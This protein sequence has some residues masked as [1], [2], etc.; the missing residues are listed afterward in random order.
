MVECKNNGR[1]CF[2]S[3]KKGNFRFI[4]VLFV[5]KVLD[6]IKPIDV[7]STLLKHFN[8]SKSFEFFKI[9][10]G[11]KFTKN[12]AQFMYKPLETFYDN[13]SQ[14]CICTTSKRFKPF[15]KNFHGLGHHVVTNDYNIFC[16][17][18][19]KNETKKGLNHNLEVPLNLRDAY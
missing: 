15:L 3:C 11:W 9:Q 4:H 16:H 2:I 1:K 7:F 8:I 6:V 5:N 10:F 14:D 18:F 19:L 17:P 12:L 13:T